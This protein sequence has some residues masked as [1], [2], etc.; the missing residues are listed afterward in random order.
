[1]NLLTMFN[2]KKLI[3]RFFEFKKYFY[4]KLQ[5]RVSGLSIEFRR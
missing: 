1:M 5:N 4:F 3:Q 2:E